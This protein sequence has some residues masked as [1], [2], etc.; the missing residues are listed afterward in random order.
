MTAY[1]QLEQRFRRLY[2]LR[3][4]TGVLWW[5]MSTMMPAGGAEA[6]SEQL[7]AL[8]VVC[9]EVIT[10]PDMAD[11][12]AEASGP[13]D[14]LDPWQRANLREMRR[15]WRHATALSPDLVEALS[16]AESRCEMAWRAAR[17]NN[18]FQGVLAPL[19]ALLSLVRE[20]AAAKAEVLDCSP[21][22]A[23][24]NL[25][26]P[27]ASAARIDE[28]FDSYAAFLPDFLER[29]LATQGE[30]GAP[31]ALEG[32]F[33]RNKQEAVGRRLMGVIGFDFTHG[34]LDTS[35]HPFC[36]GVP[37]DVR[38][39]TRYDEVSFLSALMAVLHETG[40]AMY[41]RGLPAAWRLQPVGQARGMSVHE[42]QS[43]LVEMQACRS[44]EFIAFAAPLLREAF[45]GDG[46]A[47]AAENLVRHSHRVAR[48]LIRV[49][50]DEVTYP[51]HV[52]LRSRLERAMLAGDL[53][54]ADLPAA[55]N[56]GM[57]AL[58]GVVPR[59][60]ASGCLQDIHWYDGAWGYF[61]NYT[62]G[63]MTAAQLYAAALAAVPDIPAAIGRGD[64][65][66]LMTWLRENVH[67]QGSLLTTDELLTAATGRPLDPEVFKAH[68]EARYLGA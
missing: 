32:P 62:L 39:T 12:L 56:A 65:A 9:H 1:A 45:G 60:D 23:L 50:A 10:A 4:A 8:D 21:Y 53:P 24:L 25:Y 37:D 59:D 42:S 40:H 49:D 35:L 11:L 16:K 27:G 19:E 33:A 6:R 48:G 47:W 43:L 55:W 20:S 52:I 30:R 66:P 28:I 67:A 68:L 3:E 58:L 31:L 51:A 13:T 29:V 7:A 38:I 36:G 57:D 2:A 34:R 15:E 61:P 64:F 18:D 14:G 41:E 46:P 54:L 22:E 17:P 5:D 26:D 63:A 44:P